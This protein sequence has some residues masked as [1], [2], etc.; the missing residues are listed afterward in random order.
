[1]C[2]AL[3]PLPS[4]QAIVIYTSHVSLSSG[5]RNMKQLQGCWKSFSPK[6]LYQMFQVASNS[7]DITPHYFLE[8]LLLSLETSFHGANHASLPLEKIFILM[9][10]SLDTAP[11]SFWQTVQQ[12]SLY[13]LVFLPTNLPVFFFFFVI[14][15]VGECV[16]FNSYINVCLWGVIKCL[17]IRHHRTI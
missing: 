14:T 15:A 4:R 8:K 11:L 12:L 6:S 10:L 5:Y 16:L 7:E 9:P 2:C 13:F 1:M 3:A 17:L